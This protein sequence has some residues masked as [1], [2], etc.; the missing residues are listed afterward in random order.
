MQQSI[1]ERLNT[2][3]KSKRYSVNALSKELGLNQ[4]T[5][6]NQLNGSSALSIDT[7][8]SI[9]LRFP[10]LSAEWLLRGVGSMIRE[11]GKTI[12]QVN[13]GGDNLQG[14]VINKS[15]CTKFIDMLQEKDRQIAELICIIG[16]G[17]GK[18]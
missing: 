7:I 15:D 5:L 14:N 3:L 1:S 12:Y 16:H 9:L 17:T 13:D 11:D 8:N 4:K 10:E 2:F 18:K 6:N